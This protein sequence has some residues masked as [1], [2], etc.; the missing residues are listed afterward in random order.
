[1]SYSPVYIKQMEKGLV[2]SRQEFILPNDAYPKLENAFV[3]RERIKRKQGWSLLG[4]LSRVTTNQSIGNSGASVWDVNNIYSLIPT[5]I[6][7]GPNAQIIPGSVTLTIGG[8]TF[9]D[10][11]LTGLVSVTPGNSGLVNYITGR[12]TITHTAGAGVASFISFTYAPGLPVMGI[13]SREVAATNA[14]ET[15]FFDTTY[16]YTYINSFLEF[17]PGTTWTGTDYNF[18][19]T[20]NYW[21]NAITTKIFWATNYSGR[22]G[23]PIRYTDGNAWTDFAPIIDSV[24]TRLTQCLCMI[25]FRGR[26]VTFNTLEGPNLAGSFPFTNRIRWA[27]IGTPFT[28]ADPATNIVDF[29][30][31]AWR[32]DIIGQGG[33]LDIPTAQDIVSVGFVRDNIVVYC[34]RSTWQLKYTGR[35][36]APFQIERVNSE[37]GSESTFSSVQFDTSL[38]TVGDKGIVECDSF[39]SSLIDIKIPDLVFSF[40]NLNQGTSRVCGIRDFV[41]RLAFWTYVDSENTTY[42]LKYPNRRLVYNYENQSWAIFTDSLTFM[43]NF[44][45]RVSR[46]WSDIH[47]RWSSQNVTWSSRPALI[48]LIVG[49]TQHGFIEQLDSQGTNDDS[50][51]IAGI[52]GSVTDPQQTAIFTVYDHNLQ[53]GNVIQIKILE[54]TY[55][56]QFNEMICQVTVIDKDNFN[57]RNFSSRTDSFSR[58]LTV[59]NGVYRGGGRIAVKDNF[60][61]ISKK[62]NFADV[63]ENIQ[64]GYLDILCN[65][66]EFG[67]FTINIYLDYNNSQPV[68]RYPQN[69]GNPHI[70]GYLEDPFFNSTVPTTINDT[71]IPELDEFRG[72][73]TSKGWRRVFCPVRGAFL[74]IEYTFNDSQMN[75]N[76][77]IDIQIDA[78][79]LWIRKAGKQ[80]PI[81]F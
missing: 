19:W 27:A 50:L 56:D 49:G 58:F 28:A 20:T 54:G 7:P 59:G 80:L 57:C 5:P 8:I 22:L 53:T 21:V 66:N 40:N 44:Q 60:N 45:P 34:E 12:L 77:D 78:Q 73:K 1:M 76:Q 71:E 9:E 47:K 48:P 29:N 75:E 35:S 62:F 51:M 64:L 33:F 24:G 81:G 13:C 4:Q 32:D 25:P 36:I 68:N 72:L 15:I 38:V 70:D 74:T 18:F 43:G 61:I 67:S 10:N 17:I 42:P 30:V 63:G 79:I 52:T 55:A 69:N 3:W 46:K 2:Q 14:E 39:K 31:N 23:D 37:I 6:V 26:L 11:G 41:Q 16:A 65:T